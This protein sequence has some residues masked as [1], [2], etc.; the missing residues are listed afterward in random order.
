MAKQKIKVYTNMDNNIESN[1]FDAILVNNV[2][3]YIDLVNNMFVIDCSNDILSKENNDTKIVINFKKNIISIF[4]K[5]YNKEFIKDIE[6]MFINK[7]EKKYTVKYRLID[8]DIINEYQIEF[9]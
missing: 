8:E 6:T 9:L 5:E 2:I 4:L 1:T 3:K 7:E